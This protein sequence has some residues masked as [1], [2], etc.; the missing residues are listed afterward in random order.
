MN[1]NSIKDIFEKE[2]LIIPDYNNLNIVDLLQTI[3]SRYG[4]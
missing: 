4:F 1:K 3:Y 2:N